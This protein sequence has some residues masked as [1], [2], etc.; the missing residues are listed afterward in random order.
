[1]KQ[2]IRKGL[3]E[4]IV[5]EVPDPVVTPNH[6]LIRPVCSLISSG[7]ETASIHSEGVIRAVAE[8]THHL[9]KIWEVAKGQGPLRTLAEVKAKFSEYA[10]LGYAGAGVVVDTHCTTPDFAIGDR[11]AYGGEGTGHAECVLAGR[12]LVAKVPD[13]VSFEQACFATLGSIA[14]NAV[15][16]AQIEIGDSVVVIGLGLVGQLTSQLARAQ[17][18][19]VMGMDLRPERLELA[20][21]LGAQHA[22]LADE[23][24]REAVSELTGGKGADCVIIAAAAK[25]A[26]PCHLG[27]E[28]CRERG[29]LVV[30]GAVDLSFPWNQMYLKEIQLRMSRA[31]GPGCYDPAYEKQGH[32][33][34]VSHVRW[35]ANRNMQEFL[36]LVASH[37]VQV[38]PLITHQCPIDDAA[39]AY[40]IV[41][42]VSARSLAVVLRYPGPAAVGPTGP[43]EARRKVEVYPRKTER[44]E[45][46]VALVGGANIARWVHLP[47]LKKVPG[48]RLHAVYS[49]SG[50]RGRNLAS[51]FVASYCSS[52]YEVILKDPEIDV[53]IIVSRNPDH[54]WQAEAALHAGKHVFLEKP[55]AL[56]EEE[57][58]SMFR[59]VEESGK[60]LTVGFNRRFAPFYIETK[61]QLAR[62]VG[63][64]ILNCR[65]NSPSISG[66]YW[67]ADPAIGGAIVGEACH[68]VDLMYWLLESEPIAVS[69][70]CLPIGKGEPVGENNLVAS[71]RFADGSVGNLTYCTVGSRSSGGER[72]EVFAPGIGVSTE[73]FKL[74]TIQTR[75]R[76]S[77]SQWFAQK[78][79]A[80]Q[81]RSFFAGIRDGKP[82]EV[83]VR[84]G[85][86][87]TLVC[88][89]MLESARSRKP[90]DIDLEMALG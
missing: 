35:T 47:N 70:Y 71:F 84:D 46:K 22:V 66:S 85:A 20:R 89:R 57:C 21:R 39:K 78:G 74:L 81:L 40:Q 38:E 32:D 15:R 64:A 79:Y 23:F 56:T 68:F 83:G 50:A 72:L 9:R 36:R 17:G 61:K 54:C 55:M 43:R 4:I 24:A 28:A 53:V 26:A 33:Y 8:N 16:V 76:R 6:V 34:P 19:V 42:D 7:T 52:D 49:S 67:M 44:T 1:M 5:V 62:R 12:N 80:A 37:Q 3:S 29:R 13:G 2:V 25:S 75:L 10:V 27:L 14:L 86:R 18:G 87:A 31:Y 65:I 82:P 58:R 45:L 51:R 88:L 63:P 59:A 30:L 60:H 48:V 41:A 73:D 69:A 90:C 77:R 11:V